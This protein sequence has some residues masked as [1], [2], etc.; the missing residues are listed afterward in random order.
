MTVAFFRLTRAKGLLI[1]DAAPSLLVAYR[2]MKDM[3][4]PGALAHYQIS[5]TAF[6]SYLGDGSK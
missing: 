2:S 5:S 1:F 4:V 6:A 3:I